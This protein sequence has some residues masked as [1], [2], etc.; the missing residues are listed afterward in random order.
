MKINRISLCFASLVV[1]SA[2]AS[3]NMN[4]VKT[5]C[6]PSVLSGISSL[7]N[8]DK[9]TIENISKLSKA[10]K[11]AC[12]FYE[13]NKSDTDS[14]SSNMLQNCVSLSGLLD[15]YV[16]KFNNKIAKELNSSNKSKSDYAYELAKGAVQIAPP[17]IK[18]GE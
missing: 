3:S 2:F 8:P 11:D 6:S 16:N 4:D 9:Q 13:A 5:D 7:G 18:A 14:I 10:T 12:A 15:N 17:S 1:S